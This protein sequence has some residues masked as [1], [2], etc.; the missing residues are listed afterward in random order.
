MA[1]LRVTLPPAPAAVSPGVLADGDAPVALPPGENAAAARAAR[2]AFSRSAHV[3]I[4]RVKTQDGK[5]GRVHKRSSLG[6]AAAHS[7]APHP[8]VLSLARGVRR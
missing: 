1:L 7:A 2:S 3:H 6:T 5:V 4:E 8:W